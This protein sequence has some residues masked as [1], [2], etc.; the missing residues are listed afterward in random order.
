MSTVKGIVKMHV[1][2][3]WTWFYVPWIILL[4]S[5][6]INLFIAGV[7]P[8]DDEEI[9][10]GGLSSIFI[11]TIVNGIVSV[12]QT[13]PF[14]LG[15]SVRRRDYFAG[16][17]LMCVLSGA[18]VSVVLTFLSYIEHRVI[19]GWGVRL[20]FFHLP[21]I[22]DGSVLQQFIVCFSLMVFMYLLGFT[23]SCLFRRFG[24][25]GLYTG[26]IIGL[27]LGTVLGYASNYY[28]WWGG[29]FDFFRG[30]S[31][32]DI[33]LFLFPLELLLVCFSYLLLRRCTV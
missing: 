32:F 33:A 12:H 15:L 16:S 20:Y 6:I 2:D 18:C 7:I 19:D 23:V 11:Y 10:T 27:L 5:F 29:I 25:T 9:I 14:A 3:K 24:K 4:S 22:S 13:F 30:Y 8:I 26:A 31:A 17:M 1:R 28:G 21:Y